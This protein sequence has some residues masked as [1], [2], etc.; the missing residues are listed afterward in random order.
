MKNLK[1]GDRV[2][3]KTPFTKEGVVLEVSPSTSYVKVEYEGF[4]RSS[5]WIGDTEIIEV[6][7]GKKKVKWF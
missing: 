1:I 2:L 4:G 5:I 3:Y 6:L 7:A